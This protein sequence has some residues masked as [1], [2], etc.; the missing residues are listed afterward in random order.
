MVGL[1]WRSHYSP[2]P[3]YDPEQV[4]PMREELTSI[5][6]QE[7]LTPNAVNA[8]IDDTKHTGLLVINSICGCAAGMARPGV[9][10]ALQ[11]KTKPQRLATVFAGQ[12]KE[13]TAQARGRFGNIPPSSPSVALLKNGQVVDFLPRNRIEGRSAQQVCGDLVAMFDKHLEGA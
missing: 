5:G 11:H 6:F 12:D 7:L 8:W 2:N 10:M 9:R 1:V 3:M 13:A 4:R